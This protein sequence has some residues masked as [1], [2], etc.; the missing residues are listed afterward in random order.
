MPDRLAGWTELAR[1]ELGLLDILPTLT[2]TSDLVEYIVQDTRTNNA[3]TVAEATATTG[4]TGLSRNR[5]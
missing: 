4:T 5:R 3:A 2:T 1:G